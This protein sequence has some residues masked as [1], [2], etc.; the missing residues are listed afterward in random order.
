MAG[1]GLTFKFTQTCDILLKT[2]GFEQELDPSSTPPSFTSVLCYTV[3]S[4]T[5]ITVYT[6]NTPTINTSSTY[7]LLVHGKGEYV[8]DSVSEIRHPQQ[9]VLGYILICQR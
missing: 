1:I 4:E 2:E 8:S 6:D 5:K 7:R 3:E 9:G